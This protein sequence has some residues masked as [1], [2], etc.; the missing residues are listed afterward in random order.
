MSI[1]EVERTKGGDCVLSIQDDDFF[2]K[3]YEGFHN[4]YIV[5]T[6][7]FLRD[8]NV[9]RNSNRENEFI[10]ERRRRNYDRGKH[11]KDMDNVLYFSLR[12][13][14]EE[15]IFAIIEE[16]CSPLDDLKIKNI[17]RGE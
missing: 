9:S 11:M 8:N 5:M 16:A 3:K 12:E 7:D 6:Y 10:E 14:S 1:N 15:E 2:E 13:M 17:Q 4:C